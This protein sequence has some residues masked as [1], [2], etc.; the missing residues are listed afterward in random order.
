M[1][2]RAEKY[3]NCAKLSAS[4]EERLI[5]ERFLDWAEDK[6]IFLD[7]GDG[8]L[9]GGDRDRRLYQYFEIDLKELEK[10]RQAILEAQRQLNEEL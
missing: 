1:T 10:E 2:K 4:R 5:I 7:E 8:P 3:P 9:L 6:G